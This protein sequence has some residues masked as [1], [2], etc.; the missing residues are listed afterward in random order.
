MQKILLTLATILLV[1]VSSNLF[2]IEK[3]SWT[4]TKDNDKS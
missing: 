1:I 3:G 2:A 4:L